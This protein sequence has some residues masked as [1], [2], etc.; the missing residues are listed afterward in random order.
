MP[1]GVQ[2]LL[3]AALA[4]DHDLAPIVTQ[5]S[6]RLLQRERDV[7]QSFGGICH[8]LSKGMHGVGDTVVVR[9][10]DFPAPTE[11]LALCALLETYNIEYTYVDAEG[12][13]TSLSPYALT[14]AERLALEV[15]T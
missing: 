11:R 14:E 3:N 15:G 10:A 5:L 12:T 1:R 6:T 8:T 7:L 9:V 2:A 4:N 13:Q